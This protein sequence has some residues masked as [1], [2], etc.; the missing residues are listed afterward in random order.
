[1]SPGTCH[2]R[3]SLPYTKVSCGRQRWGAVVQDVAPS[4]PVGAANPK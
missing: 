1:M 3:S 2:H 4:L